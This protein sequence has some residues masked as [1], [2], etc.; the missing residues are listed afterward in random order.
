MVISTIRIS[1]I[2]NLHKIAISL[3]QKAVSHSYFRDKH[4]HICSFS[5]ALDSTESWMTDA[6][7]NIVEKLAFF[8]WQNWRCKHC[9][10]PSW[11]LMLGR[12]HILLLLLSKIKFC[13]KCC[14]TFHW[15]LQTSS[16]QFTFFFTYTS[17]EPI[18]SNSRWCTAAQSMHFLDNRS[19]GALPWCWLVADPAQ[20]AAFW[21]S[22]ILYNNHVIIRWYGKLFSFDF[23]RC[24]V[25]H[26]F[27]TT[28]VHPCWH[29]VAAELT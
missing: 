26:M 17:R 4:V 3:I 15:S 11:L 7:L 22:V 25:V 28:H 20:C 5:T 14:H 29:P 16:P 13:C 9:W 21:R 12:I 18:F 23:A 8:C 19:N 2:A 24:T 6:N 1:N 10:L 27:I